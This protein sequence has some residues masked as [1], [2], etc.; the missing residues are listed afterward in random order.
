MT[1]I[2]PVQDLVSHIPSIDEQV[3]KYG[4]TPAE[5]LLAFERI[6]FFFFFFDGYIDTGRLPIVLVKVSSAL[7]KHLAINMGEEKIYFRLQPSGHTSLSWEVR[8]GTEARSRDE[9][10]GHGRTLHCV[11]TCFT[12]L[13]QPTLLE[14]PESSAQGS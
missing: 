8:A 2:K 11:L 5:E 12:G 6:L 9:H 14:Q 13:S 10:R 4:T 7:L 3:G 1:C